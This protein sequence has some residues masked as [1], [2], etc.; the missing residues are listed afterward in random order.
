MFSTNP[1]ATILSIQFVYK[2]SDYY[3][4]LAQSHPNVNDYKADKTH[5]KLF[6][7][8][9]TNKTKHDNVQMFTK[10]AC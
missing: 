9:P 6:K 7:N 2:M 10:K 3:C 8:D 5:K 1:P 4:Q